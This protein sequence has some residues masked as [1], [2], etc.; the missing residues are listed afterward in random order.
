MSAAA[1]IVH[2]M[3]G[4]TRIKIIAERGNPIYFGRVEKVLAQYPD[5]QRI[6]SNFRTGSVLIDHS[7]PLESIVG[8][9]QRHGLFTVE[10]AAST[11]RTSQT[12]AQDLRSVYGALVRSGADQA[13]LRYVLA[14]GLLVLGIIQLLRGQVLAPAS[15][16]LIYA[17]Q[18]LGLFGG[19][20]E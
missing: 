9:A 14:T 5:I 3:R 19:P 1:R 18:A 16:Y 17:L 7:A 6:D 12:R 8:F 11:A 15:V 10:R 2:A 4:R 13:N 20:T